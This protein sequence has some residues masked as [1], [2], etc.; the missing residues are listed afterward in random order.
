MTSFN[1]V[2]QAR[3]RKELE[4]RAERVRADFGLKPD[5][6]VD[7]AK[8]MDFG[9]IGLIDGYEMHVAENA[10]LGAAEAVTDLLKPVVTFSARTYDALC[11]GD[12]RARMTAAHE[13]GHLMLHSG[14]P[15]GLAFS[16]RDDPQI[17]P[18]RQ[19]D[20]FA[21]AFLM[22]ERAFRKIRSI[23]AAMT[24]FGVSRDAACCR[25]RQ[26]GLYRQLVLKKDLTTNKKG[27]KP[28]AR[29]P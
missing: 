14:Q 12:A 25:A 13:L 4:R 18:E 17:D 11:R 20:V 6:R 2:V 23:E 8:L 3:S 22:P 28:V 21:A 27:H 26:L 16:R 15:V 19:A 24:R 9:L 29:T 7:M 1:R 5:D 10:T